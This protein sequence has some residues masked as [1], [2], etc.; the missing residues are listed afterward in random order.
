M[1]LFWQNGFVDLH[2][3]RFFSQTHLVTQVLS[4]KR[5]FQKPSGAFQTKTLRV[6]DVN[7]KFLVSYGNKCSATTF[8]SFDHSF[9]RV[10]LLTSSIRSGGRFARLV[11]VICNYL[12]N[13]TDFM[14]DKSYFCRATQ[15]VGL[16]TTD[17][18]NRH[19]GS[20]VDEKAGSKV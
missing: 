7:A 10:A 11:L 8:D 5:L 14:L 2:F 9:A 13:S 12:H 3:G 1:F 4:R 20:L 19:L 18:V 6:I 16:C 15:S 17:C